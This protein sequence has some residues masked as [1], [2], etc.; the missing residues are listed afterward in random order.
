MILLKH[1]PSVEVGDAELPVSYDLVLKLKG[2]A[3]TV[4][5]SG[6][7]DPLGVGG[8]YLRVSGATFRPASAREQYVKRQ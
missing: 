1:R 4:T 6:A 2:E 3:C 7:D 8:I 5:I